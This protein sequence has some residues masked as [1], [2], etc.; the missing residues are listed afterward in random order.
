M[1]SNEWNNLEENLKQNLKAMDYK[2]YLKTNHWQ[3]IR[4]MI[5]KK[6]KYCQI[7]KSK[8]KLNVHH[9][10]YLNRGEEKETDLILLCNDCHSLFHHKME[11][12]KQFKLVDRKELYNDDYYNP[13]E[14]C[15]LEKVG[16]KY[17]KTNTSTPGEIRAWNILL[18]KHKKG[19]LNL[20]EMFKGGQKHEK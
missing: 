9:N 17:Y 1:N 20:N 5:V 2:E 8:D 18:E 3:R 14:K 10:S 11:Q 13:E 15:A 12:Q 7:C 6:Y 16:E 19:L 4:K